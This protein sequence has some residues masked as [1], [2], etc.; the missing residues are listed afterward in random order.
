MQKKRI[1]Y[2][3]TRSEPGGAQSHVL[4]LMRGFKHQYDLVLGTGEKGFLMDAA[5]DL[6]IPV[7]YIPSLGRSISPVKDYR[8]YLEIVD[9]LREVKP[10][11]VHCHSSKAGILGRLAAHRLGIK[12]IFTAHGWAFTDGTPP[13]KKSLGILLEWLLAHWTDRIVTVSEADRK[14]AIRYHISPAEKLVTVHNGIMNMPVTPGDTN[15]VRPVTLIMVARFAPQKD[16]SLLID[17]AAG[18]DIN[19]RLLLVGDGPQF[20]E[21]KQKANRIGIAGKTNFTGSRTDIDELLDSSDIFVLSSNW[22]GLPISILEAMRSGLPVIASDVGG[23]GEAVTNNECGI[24][25]ERGNMIELRDAIK[26][27]L[28]DTDKR[29]QMGQNA[30]A[31]FEKSFTSEVMLSQL[32]DEYA[33]LDC[34]PLA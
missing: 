6:G 29:E 30:R 7:H 10:D 2:L 4:E 11:L 28:D 14:L 22:E 5:Q 33:R 31:R 16:F 34:A 26:T 27:L 20:K 25:V 9:I 15:N 18:I 13:L 12:N 1:F 24:L 23:V 3:I 19:F 21:M 8:A 17:A 32:K